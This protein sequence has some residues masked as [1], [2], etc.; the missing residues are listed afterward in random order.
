[1]FPL[2]ALSMP[3]NRGGLHFFV[4][5]HYSLF[6]YF[7]ISFSYLPSP[8]L[9]SLVSISASLFLHLT[10]RH[11]YKHKQFI[12]FFPSYTFIEN[13]FRKCF[14]LLCHS[15]LFCLFEIK[16]PLVIQ[17]Q[18][19]KLKYVPTKW[20]QFM[21]HIFSPYIFLSLSKSSR[22][23]FVFTSIGNVRQNISN[24]S[25]MSHQD[26]VKGGWRIR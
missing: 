2:N 4:S 22:K 23:E 7:L 24:I 20:I 19:T 16:E 9:F 21:I 13:I 25:I 12:H 11:T 10:Y 5:S 17:L 8:L 26:T 3:D 15:F 1:M 18:T 14:N 6:L